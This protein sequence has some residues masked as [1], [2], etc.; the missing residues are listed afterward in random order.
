MEKSNKVNT[1]NKQHLI[2]A[3]AE[4][5]QTEIKG[6]QDNP[7][8]LQ[9]FEDIGFEAAK[10]KDETSWCSAFINWV[11]LQVDLPRSNKLTARSWL[12]VG[13]E[14]KKDQQEIG[15]VVIFWR[16]S[17]NSWKGHVAFYLREDDKWIYCLGGNQSNTVKISAY[18]KS[19]L[20]G[21]RRLTSY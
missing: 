11:C 10:L 16:D 17:P 4:A 12:K 1:C 6:T 7:R 18:P 19:R 2:I 8:I 21:Y 20:L 14:V 3:L 13:H 5:R 9:Y 15:D